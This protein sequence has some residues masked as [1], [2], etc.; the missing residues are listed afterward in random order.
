M[1]D[2][3]ARVFAR[4]ALDRLL[5]ELSAREARQ[6]RAGAHSFEEPASEAADVDDEKNQG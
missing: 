2:E 6:E 5:Q 3:L 4:V 1:L